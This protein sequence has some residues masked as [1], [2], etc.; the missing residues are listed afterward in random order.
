MIEE[1]VAHVHAAGAHGLAGVGM[2]ILGTALRLQGDLDGAAAAL[3]DGL[4]LSRSIENIWGIALALQDLA[5]VALERGEDRRAAALFAECLTV[6]CEIWDRRRIAEC[7]EGFAELSVKAGGAERAA[8]LLGAAHALRESTGSSVEPVDRAVYDRSIADVRQV[9]GEPGFT[10]AWNAGRTAPLDEALA[11]VV[12]T[13]GT[14][15]AAGA[16]PTQLTGE[17]QLSAREQEVVRLIARGLTN[18]QI[19]EQLV[20]SRRTADRHVSNILNKLGLVTRVQIAAWALE[21]VGAAARA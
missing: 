17:V 20:I 4:V 1:G 6:A 8:W 15:N 14:T 13:S 12:A 3:E 21:R 11:D 9:L 18:S 7:L 10:A 19:G 5:Q 16:Q 2:G